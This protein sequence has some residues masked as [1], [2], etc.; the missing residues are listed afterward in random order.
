MSHCYCHSK[1]FTSPHAILIVSI[2]YAFYLI[3]CMIKRNTDNYD[4]RMDFIKDFFIPFRG[5]II[6]FINLFK[7][8]K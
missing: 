4:S 2:V 6:G 8:D 3:M 1:T 7:K 5:W